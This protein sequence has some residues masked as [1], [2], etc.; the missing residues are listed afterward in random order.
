MDEFR[1][2]CHDC[3]ARAGQVHFEGC[4]TEYCTV[5]GGQRLS[6]D[7]EGHDSSKAFW[8]GY[9]PG[10]PEDAAVRAFIADAGLT[11]MPPPK[12]ASDGR[13]YAAQGDAFLRWT[14]DRVVDDAD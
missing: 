4:D 2:T 6:C 10:T 1:P 12:R 14:L 3:N 9:W 8:T 5:C 7:C 13:I 11:P